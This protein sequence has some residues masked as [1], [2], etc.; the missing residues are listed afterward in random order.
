[1]GTAPAAGMRSVVVDTIVGGFQKL[2]MGPYSWTSYFE[3]QNI[4]DAF[5]AGLKAKLPTISK[6]DTIVIYA[7]TQERWMQAAYGAWRQGLVVGTI[8]ATL[9]EEG[10]SIRHQ[11]VEVQGG[12]RRWQAAQD[13]CKDCDKVHDPQG[14]RPDLRAG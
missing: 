2:K 10:A 14:H 13:P 3:Y 7:D 12:R 1:M 8:Y 9:G 6:G 4:V 5:G 11:P